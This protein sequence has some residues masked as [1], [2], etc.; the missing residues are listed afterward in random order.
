MAKQPLQKYLA[1]Y[2][3]PELEPL[4]KIQ[5][6]F[7]QR[8]FKAGLM[9][10]AY[11]EQPAYLERWIHHPQAAQYL[12]ITVINAPDNRRQ[13]S[14]A[15]IEL[16]Q[17]IQRQFRLTAQA[18]NV[19]LFQRGGIHLLA[20][21]RFSK[22]SIPQR[23]GV[24]LVRKIACDLG[25]F[26]YSGGRLETPWIFSSDA[27]AHLPDNYFSAID[28]S[29]SKASA[30]VFNFQHIKAEASQAVFAAT[31]SYE[32][33]IKYYCQQLQYAHSPYAFFTLGS[34][35]AINIHAYTAVRGFPKRAGGEDFYI[36]NKLAKIGKV[37]HCQ[38]ITLAIEA[39]ASQRVPFGTG[40]AVR[41]IVEQTRQHTEYCYYSPDIFQELKHWLALSSQ[42]WHYIDTPEHI[43][44]PSTRCEQSL[45]RLRFA[46]F[47]QHA[48]KQ[49]NSEAVFNKAFHD[50]FDGF[51]TLKFI[52]DMQSHYYPAQALHHCLSAA[53]K[54]EAELLK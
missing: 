43:P 19:S 40:P 45:K 2:A 31:Q 5:S 17:F 41:K 36:L 16:W 18:D 3:E 13:N 42:L 33:A 53:S 11:D 30:L 46:H 10:P 48:K 15:N 37:L 51:M 32:Q 7:G 44:W 38:D 21:D 29:P 49:C 47:V 14:L 27:D 20:I 54:R 50:W 4:A 26:L 23:Q 1:C 22:L 6:C 35:L 8:C 52:R 12:L 28:K 34:T 39:R 25:V 24:G 9:I